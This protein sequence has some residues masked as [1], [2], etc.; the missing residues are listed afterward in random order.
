MRVSEPFL[1]Q[2]TEKELAMADRNSTIQNP[3][4][5]PKKVGRKK[6]TTPDAIARLR[7]VH[8]DAF[9]YSMMEYTGSLDRITVKCNTCGLVFR[10]T[11]A[12][13]YNNKTGCPTCNKGATKPSTKEEFI[14]KANKRFNFKYD[15]SL[16]GYENQRSRIKIICPIHGLIT[17]TPQ[18]HLQSATGCTECGKELAV[19]INQESRTSFSDFE[20]EANNKFGGKYAYRES[21]YEGVRNPIDI[22]CH[23]HGWFSKTGL[24]HL[25]GEG[26]P[27]CSKGRLSPN[28]IKEQAIQKHGDKFD[29]SLITDN[30]T[31]GSKITVICPSH[32]KFKTVLKSHLNGKDCPTCEKEQREAIKAARAK[33]LAENREARRKKAEI[34]FIK[35]ATKKHNGRYT[36]DNF[37]YEIGDKY[38]IITCSAHG[39][40]RQKMQSHTALGRGCPECGAEESCGWSKESYV[41]MC[42]IRSKGL[43]TLYAVTMTSGSESFFK[44]G[45]THK[46][47]KE[48]FANKED[49]PYDVKELYTVTDDASYIYDLEKRLH[50]L[51]KKHNYQPKQKFGGH[52]ECFTTIKPVEKLLKQLT[53]SDQ[54]QLIA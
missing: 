22:L 5:Q 4:V 48:R 2:L 46:T 1:P 52:T 44:V 21:T 39:D 11:Y 34:S 25:K 29:Y 38:A 26:C 3:S 19:K 32:G 43:S 36:Y 17:Q 15:Y 40:F 16:V 30:L 42:R 49:A 28:Q 41:E 37:R 24:A 8:K 9:G 14:E 12:N 23:T 50:K 7:E 54:L 18:V 33:K 10:P 6:L 13:H 53:T 35:R 45:I 51:L 31:L 47:V 20:A 27:D